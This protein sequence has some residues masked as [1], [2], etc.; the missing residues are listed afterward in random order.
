MPRGGFGLAITENRTGL[1]ICLNG[2]PHLKERKEE[3][4]NKERKRLPSFGLPDRTKSLDP[5]V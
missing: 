5:C 2:V 1:R 3:G 4:E